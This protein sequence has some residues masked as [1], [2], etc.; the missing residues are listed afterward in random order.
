[1]IKKVVSG[2]LASILFLFPVQSYA[3]SP[4][5][6]TSSSIPNTMVG[7]LT[8]DSGEV[9]EVIGQLVETNVQTFALNNERSATY[10]YSLYASN[11]TLTSEESD[12]TG[13]MKAYLTINYTL[14]DD[15]ALL[16]KVSGKWTILDSAVTVTDAELT[17]GCTGRGTS[18]IVTQRREGISVN[19]NFSK[20]TGFSKYIFEDEMAALGANIVFTLQMG[21]SRI[22]TFHMVNNYL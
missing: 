4:N 3:Y 21:S 6:N 18:G 14:N 5:D 22:W 8:S 2:I 9:V 12:S 15:M 1:M 20:T 19:N 10:E 16:T 17:Y 13:A 11:K 7:Y